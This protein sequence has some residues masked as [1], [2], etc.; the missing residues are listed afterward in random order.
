MFNKRLVVTAKHIKHESEWFAL[1]LVYSKKQGLMA[2]IE[3]YVEHPTL[4]LKIFILKDNAFDETGKECAALAAM[5]A[6]AKVMPIVV[7]GNPV[8]FR[9]ETCGSD[10]VGLPELPPKVAALEMEAFHP[11]G[12]N[13]DAE[14]VTYG[15]LHKYEFVARAVDDAM[16]NNGDSG[17]PGYVGDVKIEEAQECYGILSRMGGEGDRGAVFIKFSKEIEEWVRNAAAA[18][19]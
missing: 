18:Q 3:S 8:K 6:K 4:D 15:S 12:V 17:S 14:D 13:D 1:G 10:G 9:V 19:G 7:P 2:E 5:P 11:D 16:L